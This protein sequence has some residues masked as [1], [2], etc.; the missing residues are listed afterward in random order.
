MHTPKKKEEKKGDRVGFFSFSGVSLFQ[1]AK[2][3]GRLLGRLTSPKRSGAA[4]P[5]HAGGSSRQ[6]S[7]SSRSEG[8]LSERGE[9]REVFGRPFFF[10]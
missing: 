9:A 6:P 10:V 5:G 4:G 2:G 7:R 1:A 8:G 3:S